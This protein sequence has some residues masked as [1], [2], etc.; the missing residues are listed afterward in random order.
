M[1]YLQ[2]CQATMLVVL[3]QPTPETYKLFDDILLMSDV[4]QEVVGLRRGLQQRNKH[5]GL[6]QMKFRRVLMIWKVVL[7]SKPVLISSKTNVSFGP[8]SSSP[9]QYTA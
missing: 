3:L 2:T 4:I 7:L 6:A 5:G 1:A 8:T 9:E